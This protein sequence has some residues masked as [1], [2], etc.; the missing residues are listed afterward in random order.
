[1]HFLETMYRL[2]ISHKNLLNWITAEEAEKTMKSDLPTYIRNFLFNL[3]LGIVLVVV[4]LFTV[5]SMRLSLDLS[6]LVHLL[7]FTRLVNQSQ[8]IY[9]I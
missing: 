9:K 1:M 3:I 6:L 5:T 4:G 2:L 7:C 8:V